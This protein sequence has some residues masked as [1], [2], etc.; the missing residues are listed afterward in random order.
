MPKKLS[1]KNIVLYQVGEENNKKRC[2]MQG[3]ARNR[4]CCETSNKNRQR[5]QGDRTHDPEIMIVMLHL[6]S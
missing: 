5:P 3:N 2:S 1:Q 6:V 4:E